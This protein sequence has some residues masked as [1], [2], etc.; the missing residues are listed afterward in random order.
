MLVNHEEDFKYFMQDM[1]KIYL[2][3]RYS[4]QELMGN[5]LVPFKFRTII[6]RYLTRELDQETTLE[7]HFY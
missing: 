1:E 3:A 7:S 6:E 5:E 2:G 4:Y